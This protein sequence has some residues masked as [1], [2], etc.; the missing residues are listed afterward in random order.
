M[1]EGEDYHDNLSLQCIHPV[2]HWYEVPNKFLNGTLS[3]LIQDNPDLKYLLLHNIDTL[4]VNADPAILG[5][6]IQ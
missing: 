1:G 2:G 4:G 6:H 3:Q 5:I